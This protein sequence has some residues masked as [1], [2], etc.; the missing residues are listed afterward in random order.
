MPRILSRL[1]VGLLVGGLALVPPLALTLQ[2]QQA[3]RHYM[4]GACLGK[5][6]L[7]EWKVETCAEC[8]GDGRIDVQC[9]RCAGHG[10]VVRKCGRCGGDGTIRLT[11]RFGPHHRVVERI[12]VR[13]P[14]CLGRGV[15]YRRCPTC[16]GDGVVQMTCSRCN[17]RGQYG[18]WI[19]RSCPHCKGTGYYA[20]VPVVDSH[21]R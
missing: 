4:C 11:R 3:V 5:G 9:T 8:G 20:Y 7:R 15:V 17:G 16:G 1:L 13:C 2:A 10:T 14:R 12:T 21:R 18:Y 19:W 6:R